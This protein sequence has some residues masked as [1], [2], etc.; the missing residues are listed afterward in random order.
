MAE[1]HKQEEEDEEIL[2]L[3]FLLLML[4]LLLL[5]SFLA[6]FSYPTQRVQAPTRPTLVSEGES[7]SESKSKRESERESEREESD[8]ESG[9]RARVRSIF[10]VGEFISVISPKLDVKQRVIWHFQPNFWVIYT[11]FIFSFIHV[12]SQPQPTSVHTQIANAGDAIPRAPACC[13]MPVVCAT[14]SCSSW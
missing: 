9:K 3:L 8:C 11:N 12:G 5:T 13:R 1:V 7:E 14:C 4:L 6:S 10:L 2:F